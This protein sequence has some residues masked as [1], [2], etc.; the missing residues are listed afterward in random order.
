MSDISVLYITH[1]NVWMKY[2]LFALVNWLINSKKY[3]R[4]AQNLP[5]VLKR[6]IQVKFYFYE[7]LTKIQTK[8]DRL[9]FPK[10]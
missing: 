2:V 10:T 7:I 5:P 3:W 8:E 6:V 1:N 9:N 4:V